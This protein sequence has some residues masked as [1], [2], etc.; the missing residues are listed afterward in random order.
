MQV[1]AAANMAHEKLQLGEDGSLVVSRRGFVYVYLSYE[2]ES[3]N[4]V[5][6][7]DLTVTLKEF[8][9]V[10]SEDYYP[11]GMTFNKYKHVIGKENE[12]LY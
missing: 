3:Q 11:F 4:W 9:V 6:F 1:S 12:Y 10:Q 8:G 2:S 5:Y 7:D